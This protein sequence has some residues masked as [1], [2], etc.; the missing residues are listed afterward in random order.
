MGFVIPDS[1]VAW[2]AIQTRVQSGDLQIMTDASNG[3]GV[4]SGCAVTPQGSPNMTVAVAS[5]T[6]RIGGADVAVSSGNVTI[7]ANA[8]GNPRLDLICVNASGV[9]SAQAGTAAAVPIYP[10]IPASSVVLAAVLVPAAA[11]SITANNIVDKRVFVVAGVAASDVTSGT[12]GT[13]RL[14][15]GTANST[16]FLRGDQT[17]AT[18]P[19]G[20]VQPLE[21]AVSPETSDATT[22]TSKLTV[23]APY[24]LTLTGVRLSAAVASSSGTPTVDINVGGASV[25]STKLTIDA[26]ERTSVTAATA[27][28][29]SASY[30][31]DDAELTFDIDTAGTGTRGL[32]AALYHTVGGTPPTGDITFVAE[33]HTTYA[34]RTN[35]TVNAPS[36]LTDGD[37]ILLGILQGES[38]TNPADPTPP[39]GF[40]LLTS[41]PVIAED[42]GFAIETRVYGRVA[43]SEGASWTFT[44]TAHSSQGFAL[45]YRGVHASTQIDATPTVNSGTGAT[46]TAL[47]V[48][49]VTNNAMVVLV[50]H[51]WGSTSNNLTAPTG[52]TPTF[53]ERLDVAPLIYIADGLMVAAGA[54]GNKTMTNNT[55][56]GGGAWAAC[57]I[58]LRPA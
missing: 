14:G 5:G 24:A 2:N 49:T 18:P 39:A 50:A 25:L 20:T 55:G 52:T 15:S 51:D 43:A 28:V 58:P 34:S 4:S 57:L 48:T 32:K 27:A 7:T 23:R 16:T 1:S 17:W 44:H 11:A 38:G 37:Y 8:T 3:V 9:K 13:A 6:V 12:V 53:T 56:G 45:A 10:A 47:G 42:G 33:A 40:T 35:T 31:A 19:G 29:I 22:G 30:V 41:F 21:Y 36:G 26:S 54:T 46:S